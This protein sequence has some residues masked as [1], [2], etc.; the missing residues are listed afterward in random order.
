MI[1]STNSRQS[2]SKQPCPISEISA[3]SLAAAQVLLD[4]KAAG[5]AKAPPAPSPDPANSSCSV[6]TQGRIVAELA[7]PTTLKVCIGKN[8]EGIVTDL[9][10]HAYCENTLKAA[11]ATDDPVQRMLL[12]LMILAYHVIGDLLVKASGSTP[13]VAAALYSTVTKLMGEYRKSALALKEYQAPAAQPQVTVVNQQ[14]FTAD[15]LQRANT[16]L[17]EVSDTAFEN[18]Y[19]NGQLSTTNGHYAI[20]RCN[21]FSLDTEPAQG[22]RG[23]IEP[24]EAQ[25][26]NN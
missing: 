14:T 22:C 7:A 16:E 1:A 19:P 11:G 6:E 25:G 10:F 2:K 20:N 15:G 21:G 26:V 24:A 18:D 23:Q 17:S 12:E 5:G 8:F 13:E 4:K 9:G 3:P